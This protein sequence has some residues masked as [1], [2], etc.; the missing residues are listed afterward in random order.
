MEELKLLPSQTKDEI[1]E[2][3]KQYLDANHFNIINSDKTRPWGGFYVIDESQSQKFI[4]YFFKE[5]S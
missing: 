2:I 4:A 3:V 1:F 5:V